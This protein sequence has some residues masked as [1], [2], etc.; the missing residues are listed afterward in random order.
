MQSHNKKHDAKHANTFS[1]SQ[2]GQET[3]QKSKNFGKQI[4]E[5]S[6]LKKAELHDWRK[7]KRDFLQ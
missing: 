1:I 5:K 2:G 7:E 4:G 6:K 3:M